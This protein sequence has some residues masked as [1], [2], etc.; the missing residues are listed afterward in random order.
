MDREMLLAVIVRGNL[1]VRP[2][3]ERV[4]KSIK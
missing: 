4:W 2:G 3:G 1:S